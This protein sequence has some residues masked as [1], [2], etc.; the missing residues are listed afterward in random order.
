MKHGFR[1]RMM[2]RPKSIRFEYEHVH[3][4]RVGDR[5]LVSEEM[6]YQLRNDTVPTGGLELFSGVPVY[7]SRELP[8]RRIKR[9]MTR[10]RI[11]R[12][13]WKKERQLRADRA[14]YA[15]IR[16][17]IEEVAKMIGIATPVKEEAK[18]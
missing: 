12:D 17:N 13:A 2:P 6:L 8:F 4:I 10:R 7:L 9:P 14:K 16:R 11:R 15:E 3:C 18:P 1:P 5:Y